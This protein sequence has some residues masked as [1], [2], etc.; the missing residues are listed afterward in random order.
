MDLRAHSPSMEMVGAHGYLRES[1]DP[2]LGYHRRMKTGRAEAQL[3]MYV[4]PDTS[5]Y[6]H[7]S[8]LA[9]RVVPL[10]EVIGSLVE[11]MSGCAHSNSLVEVR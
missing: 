11:R 4:C 5:R 7:S 3:A 8:E 6:F 9:N 10:D 2:P 1:V